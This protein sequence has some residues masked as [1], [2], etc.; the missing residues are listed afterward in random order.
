MLDITVR[1][2]P[3]RRHVRPTAT[4]LDALIRGLGEEGN[5]YLVVQRV[6]DLPEEFTQVWHATDGD[7]TLEHR[8]GG[9]EHHYTASVADPAT[10]LT[11][12]LDWAHHTPDRHTTPAWTLLDLGPTPPPPPPLDLPAE[13]HTILVTHLRTLLAAGYVDR[14]QLAEAAEEYLVNGDHRPVTRAQA[15]ALADRLWLQRVAEQTT[16]EGE[17]DPE[18]LTR[19]FA[20]LDAAGITARENFTCCRTCGETEIAAEAPENARGFVYFH[21]QCTESAAT[22]HPLTLLYGTFDN[23]VT[24][25]TEIGQEITKALTAESLPTTWNGNPNTTLEIPLTWHKKL[26]G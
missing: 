17:T 6:P 21:T 18:R 3:G 8:A 1:T 11:A 22:G 14:A 5:R 2:E 26:T 15:E 12:M 19:A 23:T 13:D 25:T 24:T 10:I 9:P 16:W 7:W 4:E 20:A